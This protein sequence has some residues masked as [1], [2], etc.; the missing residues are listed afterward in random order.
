MNTTPRTIATTDE[1][2]ALPVRSVLLTYG[3]KFGPLAVQKLTDNEPAGLDY[4]SVGLAVG[5]SAQ[6]IHLPATVLFEPTPSNPKPC[7]MEVGK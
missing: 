3:N 7:K 5:Y 2:D 1:L 4:I 6:E